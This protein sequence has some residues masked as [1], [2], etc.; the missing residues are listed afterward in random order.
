MFLM[1][2]MPV[3]VLH[4]PLADCPV[5]G[6][7]ISECWRLQGYVGTISVPC[8]LLDLWHVEYRDVHTRIP[9]LKLCEGSFTLTA[10][11][12]FI[13]FPNFSETRFVSMHR[14]C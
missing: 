5:L 9:N 2:M 4:K 3:D 13:G 12:S 7:L 8:M 1:N 11:T 14:V 6:I 10:M